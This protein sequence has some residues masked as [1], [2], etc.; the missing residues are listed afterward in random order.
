MAVCALAVED[1]IEV[2]VPPGAPNIDYWP[3]E[4]VW[5][6]AAADPPARRPAADA[7][8]DTGRRRLHYSA[9]VR[10]NFIGNQSQAPCQSI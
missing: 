5:F 3:A 7:P 8:K 2:Q 6:P 1:L 9:C 4:E 10:P